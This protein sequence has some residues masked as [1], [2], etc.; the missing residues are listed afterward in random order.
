MV[1][2]ARPRLAEVLAALTST[3]IGLW[4]PWMKP[5]PSTSGAGVRWAVTGERVT[6]H[7]TLDGRDVSDGPTATWTVTDPAEAQERLVSRGLLPDG[8]CGD[9]RRG[10][11]S[12][13]AMP[14]GS[15]FDNLPMLGPNPCTIPDLVAVA[16]LGWPA[17]QRA[18]ELAMAACAALRDGGYVCPQR[19]VWRVATVNHVTVALVPYGISMHAVSV[20]SCGDVTR[21]DGGTVVGRVE[22]LVALWDSGLA[23]DAIT[24]DAVRIVVPPVGGAR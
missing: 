5:F 6:A 24:A 18:E 23:L 14:A 20:C 22:A 15:P 8:W 16:S 4:L 2:L 19:V 10:W 3:P 1:D 11:A 21:G 17:I 13:Y 7:I 12:N 9:V